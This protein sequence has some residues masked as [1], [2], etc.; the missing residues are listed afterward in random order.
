[1][2]RA[3]HVTYAVGEKR[4]LDDVSVAFEPG[5]LNLVI[6]PNGA[7]KSTLI[8]VLCNQLRPTSGQVHYASRELRTIPTEELAKMRAVLSQNV[9]V[10]FPLRAWEVVQHVGGLG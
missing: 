7:G 8:R 3:D 5:Q 10:V 2:L 9:D 6:G 1:M 4:L